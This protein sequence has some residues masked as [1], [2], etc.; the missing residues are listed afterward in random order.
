MAGS[1]WASLEVLEVDLPTPPFCRAQVFH[2]LRS[3][4]QGFLRRDPRAP[5]ASPTPCGDASLRARRGI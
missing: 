2:F 4:T 3:A 5:R 1:L